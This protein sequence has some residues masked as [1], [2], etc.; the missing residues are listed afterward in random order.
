MTTEGPTDV[1]PSRVVGTTRTH[2]LDHGGPSGT[3]TIVCL[4]GFGGSARNWDL[5]APRL[6][7]HSRVIAPD[8]YGHGLTPAP[9]DVTTH[10]VIE[11]IGDVLSHAVPSQPATP[12]VLV[13]SSFGGTMALQFTVRHPELVQAVV[14]L[15]APTPRRPDRR[16]DRG[17]TLKRWLLSAPGVSSALYRRSAS[18]SPGDVVV[19]QLRAAGIDPADLDH[20]VVRDATAL[21]ARRHH[22][23]AGHD[24]QQLLLR[25]FLRQLEHGRRFARAVA[26]IAVPVLWLQGEDDPLVPEQQARAFV[27]GHPSWEY[28]TRADVGHVPALTDPGWVSSSVHA[29]LTETK[30]A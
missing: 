13:G 20:A 24:S 28:R 21:Q 7:E 6:A 11:Q 27:A 18:M 8:L 5:V 29:W 22:D 17:M 9:P 4:H 1:P 23:R 30:E 15:A 16:R 12:A 3:T 14:L 25:S 19:G 10:D 2:V 26:P